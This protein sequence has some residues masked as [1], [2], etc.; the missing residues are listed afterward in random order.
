MTDRLALVA[1]LVAVLS[2]T[3]GC[4]ALG[5]G[6]P[7]GRYDVPERTTTTQPSTSVS[8]PVEERRGD[9]PGTET[10]VEPVGRP[11]ETEAGRLELDRYEFAPGVSR[12]EVE[13][14][15]RLAAAHRAT[16]STRSFLV[17]LTRTVRYTN[18]SQRS[19][20]TIAI[21]SANRSRYMVDREVVGVDDARSRLQVHASGSSVHFSVRGTRSPDRYEGPPF[22]EAT[23][24][25]RSRCGVAELADPTFHGTVERAFDATETTALWTDDSMVRL[26]G[27]GRDAPVD[28]LAVEAVVD[29]RGVVR[30]L[31]LA[32][33]TRLDGTTARV[34]T[35]L[36]VSR[37]G[38]ASV[39]RSEFL[40]PG[41]VHAGSRTGDACR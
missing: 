22:G 39:P 20:R 9:P 37:V 40:G 32:Y 33:E 34:T 24:P 10:T 26:R 28:D 38:S 17:T 13:D 2:V 4:N 11:P 21:L 12:Y 15:A 25:D 3:A 30:Y 7:R 19:L 5:L 36:R 8:T 14:P 41:T 23:A 18:G 27:E 29:G 1:V 31:R 16:L 35:V 6:D